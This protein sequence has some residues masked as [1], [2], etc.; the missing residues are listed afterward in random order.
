M[1]LFTWCSS[2]RKCFL[3]AWSWPS[4][5]Q[6]SAGGD[7]ISGSPGLWQPLLPLDV[8]ARCPAATL[9]DYQSGWNAPIALDGHVEEGWPR[10]IGR[11]P[12]ER[13]CM[14]CSGVGGVGQNAY[15]YSQTSAGQ[16]SSTQQSS[17]SDS[18]TDGTSVSVDLQL[19]TQTQAAQAAPAHHHHHGGH[20]GGGASDLMDT[21]EQALQSASSSDDPDQVIQD[22]L[23]K[24]LSGDGTTNA[25]SSSGT[26]SDANGKT[27]A[28]GAAGQSTD[29][30]SF[31]DFLK[32]YGV[33]A[34]QFRAD[35]LA[36]AK[37]AKNG[38]VNPATAL[39]SLP[40]GS[41]VDLT[42]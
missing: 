31:A 27:A 21:V 40:P 17:D 9:S 19:Q 6:E 25:I 11:E 4:Y 10:A 5:R 42:A 12:L 38:Q 37:D 8:L 22:A 34:Q 20:R 18:S 13:R 26:G 14:S 1:R 29:K 30:Q 32:S 2:T 16:S 3:I 41:A 24:L 28:G 23:A 35:F 39:K 7:C 33:D 15:Q 36:A